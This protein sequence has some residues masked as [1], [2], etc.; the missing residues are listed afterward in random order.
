[1]WLPITTSVTFKKDVSSGPVIVAS[2]AT[3]VT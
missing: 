2:P 3:S 1:M